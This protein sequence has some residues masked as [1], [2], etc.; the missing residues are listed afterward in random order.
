MCSLRSTYIPLCAAEDSPQTTVGLG[1]HCL[2]SVAG[3][4]LCDLPRRVAQPR[5]FADYQGNAV[6]LFAGRRRGKPGAISFG[7]LSRQDKKGN[8]LRAASQRPFAGSSPAAHRGIGVGRIARIKKTTGYRK[9][10][11]DPIVKKRTPGCLP[12]CS[13]A[14]S[15]IIRAPIE[16]SL[17]KESC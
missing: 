7:S 14:T 6:C 9:F 2:S 12:L 17:C 11:S 10:E 13:C 16:R 5:L 15:D 3:C 4:G 8:P 1:E